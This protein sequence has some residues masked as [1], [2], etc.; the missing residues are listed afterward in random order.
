MNYSNDSNQSSATLLQLFAAS[1]IKYFRN[2]SIAASMN[3]ISSTVVKYSHD[4]TVSRLIQSNTQKV[5]IP[6][7]FYPCSDKNN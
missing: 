5:F 2:S 4:W 1:F 7:P 3:A 6:C